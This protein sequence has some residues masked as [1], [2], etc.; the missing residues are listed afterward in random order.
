MGDFYYPKGVI[1]YMDRYLVVKFRPLKIK[2]IRLKNTILDM[3][4]VHV[5]RR[6]LT[7]SRILE[8]FR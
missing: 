3:P 7:T 2:F 1:K 8:T 6:R 5:F 4:T